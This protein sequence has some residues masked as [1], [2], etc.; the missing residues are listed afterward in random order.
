MH[1]AQPRIWVILRTALKVHQC[2]TKV[3]LVQWRI[4]HPRVSS[5]L[6]LWIHKRCSHHGIMIQMS[7]RTNHWC[8]IQHFH[9]P[10]SKCLISIEQDTTLE[11][12]DMFPILPLYWRSHP[13]RSRS[14]RLRSISG[15]HWLI[16]PW[17][18][19]QWMMIRDIKVRPVYRMVNRNW[20]S[21][22]TF[23][24]RWSSIQI[25][26]LTLMINWVNQKQILLDHKWLKQHL[27][28][29]I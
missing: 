19:H 4:R 10:K 24:I 6:T 29:W 12:K 28:L 17:S 11:I 22:S 14:K 13:Y 20:I 2:L 9:I 26:L 21:I 18:S 3:T 8:R 25:H 5:H 27:L 1:T 7:L 15:H 16:L 23:R